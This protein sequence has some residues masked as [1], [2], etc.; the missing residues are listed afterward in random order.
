MGHVAEPLELFEGVFP[1]FGQFQVFA[2]GKGPGIAD[3]VGQA[4]LSQPDPI[5]ID[6]VAVA[7]QDPLPFLDRNR[8]QGLNF[9]LAT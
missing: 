5:F 8:S 2:L 9:S 1:E 6:P 3:Q 4:G 7:D